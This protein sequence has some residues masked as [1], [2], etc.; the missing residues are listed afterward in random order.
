MRKMFTQKI[1]FAHM[2]A[3]L[4]FTLLWNLSAQA[5][6]LELPLGKFVAEST[7]ELRCITGGKNLSIP[8]PERWNIHKMVLKLHYTSSNNML[9]DIS[10][11]VVKFN[12]DP[13]AQAKLGSLVPDSHLDIA[14]PVN[15]L[16]PGYNRITFQVAQHYR[17]NQCEQPCA[18]D[19]WT[20]INL[21]DSYLQID[22]DLKPIPLRLG[23]A[24]NQIFDPK[25]FPEATVNLVL[26]DSS[27]EAVTMAGMVASGIARHFDYRKVKFSHSLTVK[28]GVDNVLVGTKKFADGVLGKYGIELASADGGLIKIMYP[29]KSDGGKDGL[30]ALIVISGNKTDELKIAAETFANMTLPYPGTEEMRTMGYSM[31]DIS[32]YSGRKVLASDKVY[33]FETLGVDTLTFP[34]LT[35]K[36]GTKGF[37]G[38]ASE[39]TFRLPPDFLI[40]Q[41]QYAKL[42]L[43]FSYSSGL[44]PDSSLT[45]SLNDQQIRDIHL[46]SATGNYIDGYKLELPTYLFKPGSNTISF[47]P[48]INTNR[49]VCD[50]VI[51]DGLFVTIYG[52]STLYFPPMPHFVEMPKLELFALN[53]FPFTR[54]PDGYET[55]VY[56]PQPDS[57]SID[58]AF[59]LIG[60]ITQKNGFPLFSTQVTFTEPKDWKGEMLVIGKATSIPKS[61]IANAPM[62]LDGV[63]T[64]PYPVSRGWNN[65][66]SISVSKQLS[67]LGE[68]SGLMMEFESA[69]KK[70]RS[71]VLVTAQTE[72]D[73]LAMSDA[74][75]QPG[76]QV[77]MHGDVSLV[78]LNAPDYDV[79]SLSAGK[80]YS[81]GEKGNISFID[82]ILYGNIY[83]F[84]SLIVLAIG[85]LGMLV[86]WLLRRFRNRRVGHSQ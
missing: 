12:G 86:Y 24:T 79:T 49:Q 13:V 8:I 35:G 59:N 10:Q 65:E 48:Y 84:Y 27:P 85:A 67:G 21:K 41:N 61:L 64:V 53:G 80:K 58:T 57:A 44:R 14:L 54:W 18:P 55:L 73:L 3:I 45:I 69:Q 11:I 25:Q 22:Y 23:E 39:L 16:G 50:A 5:E 32:M 30:H 75:L 43:N 74:L 51:T 56:V 31:P 60:M 38:N 36:S 62:Q 72:K 66:T 20:D 77:Q 26:D 83:L 46:D 2:N 81:T 76:V 6:T 34:G 78:K 47:K 63:A 82:S 40:K 68:G 15:N 7:M 19:L 9:S 17:E 4:A 29:P 1:M 52:N 70:G 71:V 42:M 37:H 28:P 33:D